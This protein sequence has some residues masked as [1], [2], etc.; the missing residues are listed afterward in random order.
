MSNLLALPDVWVTIVTVISIGVGVCTYPLVNLLA[1]K[2]GKK[3][4]LLGACV[5]YVCL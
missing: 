1:R 2:V 4:M 5:T 3:P